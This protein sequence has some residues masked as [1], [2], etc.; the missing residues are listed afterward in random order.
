M[1]VTFISKVEP[2]DIRIFQYVSAFLEVGVKNLVLGDEGGEM[3][4]I[5]RGQIAGYKNRR[6][7]IYRRRGGAVE[8]VS[9][10][11]GIIFK[12]HEFNL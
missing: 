3:R 6:R 4:G 8:R 5:F 11:L 12:R 7:D 9:R 1:K 10:P 2:R